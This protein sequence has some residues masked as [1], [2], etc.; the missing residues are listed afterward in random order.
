MFYLCF[1]YFFFI[2]CYSLIFSDIFHFIFNKYNFILYINLIILQYHT[3]LKSI[4][5][6]NSTYI[7]TNKKFNFTNFFQSHV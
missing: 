7:Y 4:H 2:N 6:H 1:F 5:K 3:Y